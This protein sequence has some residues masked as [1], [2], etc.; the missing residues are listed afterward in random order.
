MFVNPEIKSLFDQFIKVI[1]LFMGVLGGLFVLGAMTRRA[2]GPGA[3]VGAIV[4]AG[5]MFCLWK[6]TKIN[7]YLY[8]AAGIGTCFVVGYA[9]SLPFGQTKNIDGL[10]VYSNG[11]AAGDSSS[12]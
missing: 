10:T 3:L 9:A 1:G 5:T 6:F 11:A 2:N 4:G 12:V 7:G 8:T